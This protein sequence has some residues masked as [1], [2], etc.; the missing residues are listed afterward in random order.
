MKDRETTQTGFLIAFFAMVTALGLLL[1]LLFVYPHDYNRPPDIMERRAMAMKLDYSDS[2]G[3]VKEQ[4]DPAAPP[5]LARSRAWRPPAR[6]AADQQIRKEAPAPLVSSLSQSDIQSMLQDAMGLVDDGNPHAAMELLENIIKDDP[7]NEMALIEMGMIHLI[8]MKSPQGAVGYLKNALE[9]NPDNKVVISELVGVFDE[10]GQGQ[11]GTRY[12]QDLYNANP[13]N[14]T[15]A[16]GIGQMLAGQN[17]LNEALPYL[18][19]SAEDGRSMMAVT[20]L[21]DAYSRAG[22]G[23]KA[24]DTY[25]RAI[26]LEQEKFANGFYSQDE[27]A[28]RKNIL[29]AHA[30]HLSELLHQN[31]MAEARESLRKIESEYP[32]D[33]NELARRM[34]R[35]YSFPMP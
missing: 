23:D 15:L 17:R 10:L 21:A 16:M 35:D 30:D 18:E 28:G 25:Q 20:D 34:G 3:Q 24:L 13:G 26:S 12:L 9:V 6:Q 32:D 5:S 29:A 8:D 11:E 31:K 7:T 27:N 22:H 19:K 4:P 14:P 2:S 1:L 33:M